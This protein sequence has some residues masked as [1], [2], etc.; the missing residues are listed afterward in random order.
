MFGQGMQYFP[1]KIKPEKNRIPKY[2]EY[3]ALLGTLDVF[4]KEKEEQ[5]DLGRKKRGKAMVQHIG[6]KN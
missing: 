5:A 4:P 1:K 3:I 2:W 6:G